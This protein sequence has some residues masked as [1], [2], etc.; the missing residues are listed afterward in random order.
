MTSLIDLEPAA[1]SEKQFGACDPGDVRRT[2]RLVRYAQQMAEKPDAIWSSA[3]QQKSTMDTRASARGLDRS[4]QSTA[5]ASF[6]IQHSLSTRKVIR[7]WDS[8][9]RNSGHRRLANH[10][11]WARNSHPRPPRLPRRSQKMWVRMS[12]ASGTYQTQSFPADGSTHT[13]TH[14]G[15]TDT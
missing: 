8:A 6:C 9:C 7:S 1:W 11:A 14:A 4:R 10:L 15:V 5:G 12:S 2:Q 3:I 13:K